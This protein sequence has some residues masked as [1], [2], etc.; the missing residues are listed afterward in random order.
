MAYTVALDTN[1]IGSVA[2]TQ[3]HLAR[4]RDVLHKRLR[5][6]GIHHSIEPQANAR[7]LVRVAQAGSGEPDLARRII[8]E[9]G[10]IEFRIVHTNSA[11]LVKEGLVESGYE[12]IEERPARP[13]KKQTVNHHL[14]KKEPERGLTG[15]YI[16]RTAV[17][18]NQL[19]GHPEVIFEFDS[20]GARLFEEI[21][22][23]YKPRGTVYH[24]LAIVLNGRLYSAPRI[25]DV[26]RGGRGVMTGAFS[27]QEA[28]A[29]ASVLENPLEVPYSIVDEKTF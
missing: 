26:V 19:T 28:M 18:R 11:S 25:N 16:K 23:Q 12:V 17:T 27:V 21:T 9:K 24:Q 3:E 7:L 2:E 14:V 8:S 6:M 20:K 5:K 13:D 29:L 10:L 4:T 1:K 22:D 15:K